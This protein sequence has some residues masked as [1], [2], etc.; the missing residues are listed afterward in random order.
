MVYLGYSGSGGF[1]YTVFVAIL[2]AVLLTLLLRLITA[3]RVR[4][5]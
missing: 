1:L 2:G 4:N 5:F 3:G